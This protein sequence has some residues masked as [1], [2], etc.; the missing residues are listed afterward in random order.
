MMQQP[1]LKTEEPDGRLVEVTPKFVI[2]AVKPGGVTRTAALRQAEHVIQ[3]SRG[4]LDD[5]LCTSIA[6]LVE[7]T[8]DLELSPSTDP[9]LIRA[10]RDHA[11]QLRDFGALAGFEMVTSIAAMLSDVLNAIVDGDLTFRKEVL[12]CFVDPL[13]LFCCAERRGAST[14]ES[15]ELLVELKAMQQKLLPG[16]E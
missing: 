8:S 3:T 7:M 5:R 1:E 4:E 12:R 10:Y 13:E 11:R 14:F 6:A 16:A 2:E 15:P 9:E